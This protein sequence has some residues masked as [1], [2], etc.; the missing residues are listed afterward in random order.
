MISK[1]TM[2]RVRTINGGDI[3]APLLLNYRNTY[4]VTIDING[5]C[6]VILNTRIRSV[7]AIDQGVA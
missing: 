2:V 4:D 3:V 1:G 6:V 5:A 7:E